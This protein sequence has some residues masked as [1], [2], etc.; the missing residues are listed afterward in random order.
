MPV[1]SD[2]IDQSNRNEPRLTDKF[3]CSEESSQND[4]SR[5]VNT[6]DTKAF[7]TIDNDRESWLLG[8]LPP[9]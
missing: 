3:I 9:S 6:F 4:P 2:I 8:V 5:S 1:V 7:E